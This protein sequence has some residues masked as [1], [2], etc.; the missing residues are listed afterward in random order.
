MVVVF[1][2]LKA[3]PPEA[4]DQSM[5]G[6]ANPVDVADNSILCDRWLHG[7]HGGFAAVRNHEHVVVYVAI[8]PLISIGCFLLILILAADVGSHRNVGANTGNV[9]ASVGRI[10][11]GR[12]TLTGSCRAKQRVRRD[13]TC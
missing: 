9:R 1:P 7:S 13:P 10:S 2:A 8:S 11:R 5:A 3:D 6:A 4:I 12:A